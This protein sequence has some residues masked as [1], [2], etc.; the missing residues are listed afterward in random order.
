[1][2][3][4][5]CGHNL[6]YTMNNFVMHNKISIKIYK[7]LADFYQQWKHVAQEVMGSAY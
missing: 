3:T 7:C 1:M 2:C 6:S 4:E 5:V